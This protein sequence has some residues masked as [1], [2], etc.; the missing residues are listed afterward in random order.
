[1]TWK[2]ILKYVVTISIV[3]MLLL[4]GIA[5]VA[6]ESQTNGIGL[7]VPVVTKEGKNLD[8]EKL[9][10]NHWQFKD[11]LSLDDEIR[12]KWNNVALDLY[13]K[14]N[15][16]T[17]AG[18]LKVYQGDDS[19]ETNLIAEH[20]SS[21]FPL[22]LLKD[23]VNEGP[24]TLIFV[25]INSVTQEPYVP[26]T[27]VRLDFTFSNTSSKPR[28]QIVSPSAGVVLA[29]G[30]KQEFKIELNNYA[31]TSSTKPEE[32]TG[33][34]NIYYDKVEQSN[35][36]ATLTSS[37]GQTDDKN[38]HLVAFD[39][40]DVD[41][42]NIPDAGEVNLIFV[43]TSANGDLSEYRDELKVK[44]NYKQSL[45]LG[46]PRITIQE[47]RKDRLDLSLNGNQKFILQV[48]NFQIL[49]NF[50]SNAVVDGKRGYLQVFVDNQPIKTVW[51]K[52]EFSLNELGYI[53]ETEGQKTIDVQL[54]NPNF[55]KLAPEAR[56]SVTV[57][58][59]PEKQ[60]Q[61]LEAETKANGS[62][63]W[64]IVIVVLVIGM[65]G[66]GIVLLITKG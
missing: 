7:Q 10:T 53:S 51:G 37:I 59:V 64:R 57:V 52:T 39:S 58:Y 11:S 63:T 50:E 31:L 22:A 28:L 34:L 26:A 8:T 25:Y 33:K 14:N 62:D 56:D 13:Y 46:L 21:P 36:V 48:D 9:G 43:L 29:G 41:F 49:E 38:T 16:T 45:D 17:G 27:K 3:G 54:V 18:W 4:S 47:P 6:Q 12:Y 40:D 2:N 23:K 20:G 44:T 35:L 24:T 1:M 65:I 61:E 19:K 5:S 15:P 42:K 60:D 32:G 66:G 30:V 55:T